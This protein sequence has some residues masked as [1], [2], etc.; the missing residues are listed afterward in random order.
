MFSATSAFRKG[1][2]LGKQPHSAKYAVLNKRWMMYSCLEYTCSPH[3]LF[4]ILVT[5][6]T[7]H[8]EILYVFHLYLYFN[9]KFL[10][11]VIQCDTVMQDLMFLAVVVLK[12]QVFWDVVL[13]CWTQLHSIT[14]Q[15]T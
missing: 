11:P 1:S 10:P 15:K 12:I 4:V 5:W 7:C 3:I 2:L 13:C 8:V 6:L 14:S 9:R